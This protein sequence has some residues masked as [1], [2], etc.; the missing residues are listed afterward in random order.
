VKHTSPTLLVIAA[1]AAAPGM[2]ALS[3]KDDDLSLGLKLQLQVRAEKGWAQG[4]DNQA[5]N[6]PE[7]AA[8]SESDVMDFYVRRARIGFAGTWKGEYKFAYLMRA[9]NQ[10]KFNAAPPSGTGAPSVQTQGRTPQTHYAFVERIIKQ[11]DLGLEHGVRMGLDYAWFNGAS[12]AFS[13]SS[14][15]FPTE[16]ATAGMV[17]PRG[18]GVGYKLSHK[19]VTWGVDVQNNT[20]DAQ[21]IAG[22]GTA[23]QGEGL[24]MG[25]RVQVIAYDSD[26]KGHMKTVES[27]L[28]KEGKGVLVSAEYGINDSNNITATQTANTT[29]YGFEILGHMDAIT[30]LAEWRQM[31]TRTKNNVIADD[32]NVGTCYLIQIGYALPMGD[33]IL[34]PAFRWTKLDADA[35]TGETGN[36]GTSEYGGS[37]YSWDLGLNYYIHGHSNKLQL[38][39]QHWRAEDGVMLGNPSE[40]VAAKADVLRFQWGLSF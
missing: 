17:G 28:G 9:D 3:V 12:A 30:A 7:A 34:E 26:E 10:D 11:E 14:F 25:S 1:L 19:K 6:V 13:S 2:H 31:I 15:L 33:Q 24:F 27:F 29:A 40:Y 39:W 8:N 20:G 32:T 23:D 4:N 37:G 35:D 18:V 22:D 36:Y 16:R 5:Y 21:N 38:A